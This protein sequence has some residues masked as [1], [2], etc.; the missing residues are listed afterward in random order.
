MSLLIVKASFDHEAGVWY[1]SES[2]VPGLATEARTLEEL[3]QK[4][5]VMVPKLLEAN[6]VETG[7]A[8]EIPLEI[9]AHDTVRV[10]LSAA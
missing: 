10:R 1:V 6:G 2:D 3:R 4:L 9:I 8:G 5:L 7:G